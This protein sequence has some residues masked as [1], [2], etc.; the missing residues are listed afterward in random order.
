M[1]KHAILAQLTETKVV[2]VIR[3]NS[4]EEAVQLTK[5][6]VEGGIRAIELTYTT[7]QVQKAFEDLQDIDALLGAGTVLDP[8]TARHAILNGAKFIV[9][10]HFNEEVATVC[11]RYGIPYLPGCMTIREMVKALE[12]GCDVLKL[13]PANNFNPSFINSVK[14]PLPHAQIMPTGGINAENMAEWLDAGAVA[15]GVGSDLNKAFKAG[16]YEAVVEAS[17]KFMVASEIQKERK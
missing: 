13:F 10:P 17:K 6:A 14:G 9:S 8:E 3:G 12:S 11:N 1:S 7:P 5:A 2:A 15:V 16:G 4:S